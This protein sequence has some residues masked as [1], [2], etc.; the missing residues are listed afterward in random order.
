[1]TTEATVSR[2]V[3]EQLNFFL[4]LSLT[5]SETFICENMNLVSPQYLKDAKTWTPLFFF[6]AEQW[7]ELPN[8]PNPNKWG[9]AMVS[10]NNDVYVTGES[11][12]CKSVKHR[13]FRSKWKQLNDFERNPLE[14]NEKCCQ[15][16]DKA[17]FSVWQGAREARIPTPG[18]PQRPGSTSQGRGGGLQWHPCFGLELTTRRQRSMGRFTSLEVRK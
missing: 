18:R 4:D 5:P 1:M 16:L 11:S 17:L 10:L 12:V 2:A 14:R 3:P 9:Y 8:F 15:I 7:H 13:H 6:S